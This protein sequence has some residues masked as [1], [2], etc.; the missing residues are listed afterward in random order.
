LEQV[1]TIQDEL[2]LRLRNKDQQAF[3]QMYYQYSTSLLGVISRVL[4]NDLELAR[5]VLQESMVKIWN[6]ITSYDSSKGTL[7]T[8]ML[9]ICR[10]MAIDKTRSRMYKNQQKS[11]SIDTNPMLENYLQDI[12]KPETIGLKKMLELLDP[13][14]REVV[15]AVYLMGYTHVEAAEK[16]SIPLGTVKTRLRNAILELR[17]YF[18]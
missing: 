14:Q 4:D 10:N 2:V 16:L 7:F 18:N 8:W 13:S 11:Q 1:T 3:S 9:N 15:D 6:N 12:P 5:D 17:K